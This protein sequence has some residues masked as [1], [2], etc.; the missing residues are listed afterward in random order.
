MRLLVCNVIEEDEIPTFKKVALVRL[1][2]RLGQDVFIDHEISEANKQ[3]FIDGMKAYK[4]LMNVHQVEGYKACATSAMR[5]S[6]NGVEIANLIKEKTGISIDIIDGEE[7]ARIIQSAH[8]KDKLSPKKNY[9]YIDVG[10]GSTE[11]TL[12]SNGRVVDSKSFKIGTIRLLNDMVNEKVWDDLKHWVKEKTI[13]L[14]ELETIGSGGN[15]NKIYKLSKK[16]YPKPLKY[17]ELK[18]IHNLLSEMTVDERIKSLKLNTDRADVIVPASSIFVST[19]KWAESK[20]LHVPKIGLAD[21]LVMEL[22][23]Q[24]LGK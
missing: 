16:S 20:V 24:Q 18:Q 9:I 10:G 12:F 14:P 11:I 8:F 19:M 2:I 5:E 3:R 23:D 22:Y 17:G 21:G 1:P 6:E 13:N 15:I 7:E 4:Y